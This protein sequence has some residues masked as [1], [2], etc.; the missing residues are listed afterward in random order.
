MREV[1]HT[2]CALQVFF[3]VFDQKLFNQGTEDSLHFSQHR[4]Y[5][6]TARSSCQAVFQKNFKLF[7][8]LAQALMEEVSTSR[9]CR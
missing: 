5:Y 1:Y 6:D 8:S 3:K 4:L 9:G 7:R 2:F